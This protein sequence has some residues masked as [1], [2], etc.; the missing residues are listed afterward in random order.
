MLYLHTFS[1]ATENDEAGYI[2]SFS[3]KLE[4]S[5]YPRDVYPFKIF[6]QK[7]IQTLSFEPITLLYGSNGSGKSTLLNLIAQKLQLER[8]APFNYTPF[9]EEYLRL[10]RYQT[11]YGRSIP[12]GSRLIASDDVFDFLL[13]ARA[14][15][16]GFDHRREELFAEY[17]EAKT[18]S[19]TLRTLED[20]EEL[21]RHN[22]AKRK[23]KSVFVT[24]RLPNSLTGQSNGESA[25]AY[26]T[27]KIRENALY[28]LDEP[29]NSL[30][31][32]LQIEL[33][34]FI[35]DATRFYGCQFI[36]STHSPFLLAMK[37]AKL[38]DLDHSPATPKKWTEL[39]SMRLYHDFFELHRGEF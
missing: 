23:T 32:G 15:N 29:E 31:A 39:E 1:L 4:M 38:Y 21:K 5:C 19:F 10:C 27:E 6:P 24:R 18:Q 34:R 7:G 22:E 2:L 20:Y 16:E 30:S 11:A 33:K 17:M 36:I 14:I 13:N 12:H 3:Y 28:L 37:D 35:E 25:F 26:F 8:D 9:Y